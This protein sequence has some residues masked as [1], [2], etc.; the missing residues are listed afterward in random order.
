MQFKS[1][2]KRTAVSLSTIVRCSKCGGENAVH[3]TMY[4]E[5]DGKFCHVKCVSDED[6]QKSEE[7]VKVHEL[8]LTDDLNV[9]SE[10]K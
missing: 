2:P 3:E 5:G 1:Y 9:K 4:D 7:T 8:R 6:T 10:G